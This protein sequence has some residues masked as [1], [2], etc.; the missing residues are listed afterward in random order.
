MYSIG[1]MFHNL[2]Y[3]YEPDEL[4]SEENNKLSNQKVH[5]S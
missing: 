2:I 4:M 1:V 5:V 3:G